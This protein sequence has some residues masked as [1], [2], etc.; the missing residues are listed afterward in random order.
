MFPNFSPLI[1]IWVPE[2]INLKDLFYSTKIRVNGCKKVRQKYM[3]GYRG[4]T[5]MIGL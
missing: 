5:T 2:V 4:G 3:V 1:S